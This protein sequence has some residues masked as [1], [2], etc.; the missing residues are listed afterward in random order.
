MVNSRIEID[1]EQDKALACDYLQTVEQKVLDQGVRC[2]CAV[3]LAM[4]M[5]N[6]AL[7]IVDYTFKAKAMLLAMATH[8]AEFVIPSE[9]ARV[10]EFERIV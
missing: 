7:E 4:P 10:D 2:V 8:N 3:R 5:S 6:P 1:L 9:K